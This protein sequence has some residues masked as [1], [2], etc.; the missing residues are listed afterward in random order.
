MATARLTVT[1][2]GIIKK[3]WALRPTQIARA[4]RL[5]VNQITRELE[6]ELGGDIPREHGTSIAGFKRVRA[7]KTLAKAR[8]RKRVRGIT[9]IGR[10]A[11]A[12][13]YA[14]KPRNVKGGARA[15]RYFFENAFVAKMKSGHVGIFRR[16]EGSTKIVETL[17][18]LTNAKAQV[19]RAVNGKRGKIRQIMQNQLRKQTKSKR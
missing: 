3:E 5:T 14:G 19:V 2:A 12:S 17:V 11:I 9:W 15:G 6:K 18:E 7:K 8:N 13:A 4:S 1:G 16:I 10:N